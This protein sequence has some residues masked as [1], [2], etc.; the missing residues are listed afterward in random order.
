MT[1]SPYP[2]DKIFDQPC[3]GLIMQELTTYKESNGQIIRTTVTRQ[4]FVDDYL[5]S[6]VS[7]PIGIKHGSQR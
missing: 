5:D 2:Y 1:E 4:F 3:E 7:T 6:T